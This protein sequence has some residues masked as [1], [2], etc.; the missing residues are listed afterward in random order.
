MCNNTCACHSK[1]FEV[2]AVLHRK[3]LRRYTRSINQ[4]SI[5]VKS[6]REYTMSG[7]QGWIEALRRCIAKKSESDN[8]REINAVENNFNISII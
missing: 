2:Y 3:L 4:D 7:K 1:E 8:A 5:T 6:I